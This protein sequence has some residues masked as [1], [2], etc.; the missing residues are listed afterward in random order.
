MVFG[1]YYRLNG[2]FHSCNDYYSLEK[3]IILIIPKK[4]TYKLLDKLN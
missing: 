2:K 4:P 1:D 3:S